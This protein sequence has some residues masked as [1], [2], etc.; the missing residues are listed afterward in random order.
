M[1]LLS[2]VLTSLCCCYPALDLQLES[3]EGPYWEGTVMW[4]WVWG[5]SVRGSV[6]SSLCPSLDCVQLR[7]CVCLDIQLGKINKAFV[8]ED[9]HIWNLDTPP[10][11]PCC[12]RSV[13]QSVKYCY[14]QGNKRKK[15]AA[16]TGQQITQAV[17]LETGAFTLQW[18]VYS[19]K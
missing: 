10:A 8:E 3:L 18:L 7:T 17:V 14:P 1:E 4:E 15:S 2:V 13:W 6:S 5:F 19:R 11:L 12:S 9:S 16:E